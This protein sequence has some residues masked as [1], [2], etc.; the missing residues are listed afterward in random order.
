MKWFEFELTVT[1]NVEA[2]IAKIRRIRAESNFSLVVLEGINAIQKYQ[3]MLSPKGKDGNIPRS[4]AAGRIIKQGNTWVGTSLTNYGPAIFTNEGTGIHGPL[5][6]TYPITQIRTYKKGPNAGNEYEVNIDHPGI[7]GT[8]WW[9]KGAAIGST[10]ALR[11][12]ED[13]VERLLR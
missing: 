1:H 4:I 7:R 10:L 3:R 12:F 8:H 2:F 6:A 9:E 11:S 5:G 13:K